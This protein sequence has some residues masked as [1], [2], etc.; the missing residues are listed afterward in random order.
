MIEDLPLDIELNTYSHFL[1][2]GT[3][4]YEKTHAPCTPKCRLGTMVVFTLPPD[5]AASEW[6]IC[7]RHFDITT[8]VG[9]LLP[10]DG[11]SVNAVACAFYEHLADHGGMRK[12]IQ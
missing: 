9:R 4:V 10:A 7:G 6:L 5:I 11:D 12:A 8:G 2:L 3:D 1:C